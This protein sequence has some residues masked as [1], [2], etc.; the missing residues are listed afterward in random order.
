[1]LAQSLLT[2]FNKFSQASPFRQSQ[3]SCGVLGSIHSP[4]VVN[5]LECPA[6]VSRQRLHFP[7]RVNLLA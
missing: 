6:C 5:L 4:S 7:T 2:I 3:F 1:M